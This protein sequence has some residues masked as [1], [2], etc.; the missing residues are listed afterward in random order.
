MARRN[1]FQQMA[2]M[3]PTGLGVTTQAV[4]NG[5][6]EDFEIA[7][8]I[9]DVALPSALIVLGVIVVPHNGAATPVAVSTK[10]RLRLYTNSDMHID[11]IIYDDDRTAMS[12]SSDPG[13]DNTQWAYVDEEQAGKIYGKIEILG[14]E[15]DA[16]FTIKILFAD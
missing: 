14:G 2:T 16:T 10:W 13:I 15:N 5:T 11:D 3:L 1:Q 12:A 8:D 9:D 6:E 4:T 7:A